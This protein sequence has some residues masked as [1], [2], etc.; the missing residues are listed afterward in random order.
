MPVTL[1]KGKRWL[2]QK[3][4][5]WKR[6]PV[7]NNDTTVFN[8]CYLSILVPLNK[9]RLWWP[10]LFMQKLIPIAYF[11]F[12]STGSQSWVGEW[13]CKFRFTWINIKINASP[14]PQ[15][16]PIHKTHSSRQRTHVHRYKM[17]WDVWEHGN[18]KRR[19]TLRLQ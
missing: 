11:H 5:N 4:I 2:Q 13:V 6:L 3:L 10:N 7:L 1:C 15:K 14:T 17:F 16:Y 8:N 9:K 19:I 18:H 12:T